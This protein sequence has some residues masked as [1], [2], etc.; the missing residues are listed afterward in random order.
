[1]ARP[2]RIPVRTE[3]EITRDAIAEL[4]A[5][6]QPITAAIHNLNVQHPPPPARNNEEQDDNDD[7]ED[8]ENVNL[9]AAAAAAH[10]ANPFAPLCNNRVVAPANVQAEDVP[11]ERGFKTEIPEFHG[12]ASAEELLDWLVT[13]EEILEFKQVP[14]ERCVPV[15]SMRFRGRAAPWWSQLKATRARLGKPKILSW[16]KLKSKLKKTFLPYNYDQLMF[17]RLHT[18]RQGTRS[19]SERQLVAQFTAGLRQQIQHTLNLFNP[20]TLSEAHQQALTIEARTKSSFSSWTNAL[21][22]RPNQ[23]QPTAEDTVPVQKDAAIVPVI[24]NRQARPSSLRCFSCGE[25]GHRQAN[26]PTRNRRGLLLD[27]AGNDVEVIYDE[28]PVETPDEMEM[29]TADTRTALMLRRVCLAPRVPDENPQR[30]NLFHSKCTIGGKV[31]KF[32]IDS[33]SSE[34]V[35]AEEAVTKL[36]LPTEDH[37]YPYKLAW[38]DQKTDLLITRRA[39][40]TFSVGDAYKDQIHCDVAPMDACHLLL[41]RPW[42]YDRRILHDGYK[43][44]YSFRFQNRNFTLQPSVPEKHQPPTSPVL[45][46]QRKQFEETFREEGIVF[47]IINSQTPATSPAIP[48]EFSNILQEFRDVFPD[49]LPPGLPP[50]RDIQHRIDLVPDAILPNR[51]HYRMSPSEHEELRRQVED[52]VAKGYLRESLSPCAVPAL[53]IPKKDGS[54]RMCVDS[55]AINKITVRYRFPIPRLDDLLD[56]IGAATVFSKLDLRSGYHQI[57]IRPGDEWKTAFKTREG[58]F[59]WLVMPFGLSNA[60]STFMRVMNQSLRPFIGKFVVVYF[61]DI[62]IFSMTL[63]EHIDHLK[64]VLHVLRRDQLFATLKKCEFG[65]PQVNFLGYIVSAQGLAVDPGKV[66]AIKS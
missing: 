47:A 50:L 54:W 35:I 20:L 4:Q 61:D 34:N 48:P 30:K 10:D 2:R 60:P 11:W 63:S 42:I 14:M 31:C 5:Q 57:R 27:T 1:M 3:A 37:P 40:I 13:V 26:C 45:F 16:D 52:L 7:E 8:D 39:L 49:D 17:Q 53:L 12:N 6:M 19:D 56:Q 24:D 59:E 33:G 36:Q 23:T 21:S 55:R 22:S 28:E 43:N 66:E 64:E 38:L 9:F 15:L 44:T 29:L 46:L 25:I 51:A 58:L 32:I 62:L 41:G 18:I 65:S